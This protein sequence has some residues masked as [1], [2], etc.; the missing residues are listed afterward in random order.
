MKLIFVNRFFYPDESA[1]SRMVSSLAIALAGE[2]VRVTALCGTRPDDAA[3]KPGRESLRGVEIVRLATSKHTGGLV[4]RAIGDL[5][6][7]LSASF[8]LLR[9]LRRGDCCVICTD[10][11]MLS[12]SAAPAIALRRATMVNW[13]FDLFPEVAMEL[14]VIPRSG[15][16]AQLSVFLRDL[17]LRASSLIVCPTEA[18]ARRLARRGHGSDR[19]AV[20][21]LWSDGSEIVPV[22]RGDNVLRRDWGYG[23]ELVIGHSGNFGMAHDFTTLLGAAERLRDTPDV[24]FLL[25]GNGVKRAEAEAFVRDRGLT[26][27]TF[28]H[29]QPPE[30]L[31]QSMSVADAHVVSLNPALESC[32]VPSKFYGVLAAGRPTLFVGDPQGEVARTAATADC[33]V[34]V[35]IGDVDGLVRQFLRL[36]DDPE[37]RMAMGRRARNLFLSDYTLQRGITEWRTALGGLP[38]ASGRNARHDIPREITMTEASEAEK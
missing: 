26:N 21:R 16:V 36:R 35:D 17:S 33:G 22:A 34:Q 27:V 10:P 4:R 19:L 32:I 20:I 3:Q 14:G 9:N 1:T 2:G 11:P 12:V 31:S 25:I 7:H 15:M 8:W 38:H 5:G 29:L 24:R 37:R 30:Q 23:D 18:M 13:V 6:F 28:E